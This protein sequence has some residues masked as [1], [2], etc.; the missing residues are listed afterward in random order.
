[1]PHVSEADC[2]KAA[3][4]VSL[5]LPLSPQ[6]KLQQAFSCFQG[7]VWRVLPCQRHS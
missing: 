6:V 1:M 3:S 7:P 4:A 5:F 2:P